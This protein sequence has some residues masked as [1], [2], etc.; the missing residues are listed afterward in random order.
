MLTHSSS[1]PYFD[2]LETYS[3]HVNEMVSSGVQPTF[4][5]YGYQCTNQSDLTLV[6]GW[7]EI[8]VIVFKTVPNVLWRQKILLHIYQPSV[9][10]LSIHDD[11]GLKIDKSAGTIT[12]S[13]EVHKFTP[14]YQL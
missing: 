13:G 8:L 5:K 14:I 2:D 1:L 10:Q 11:L 4:K 6:T 7:S 12:I 3:M 9:S